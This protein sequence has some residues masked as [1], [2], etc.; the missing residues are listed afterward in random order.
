MLVPIHLP[1][2]IA[3]EEV[4]KYE[5][6]F[7]DMDVKAIGKLFVELS[8]FLRLDYPLSHTFKLSGALAR[9]ALKTIFMK[10]E[11]LITS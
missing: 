2:Y 7:E 3:R 6:C 9:L 10:L 8:L 5:D 4:Q 11:I 1:S